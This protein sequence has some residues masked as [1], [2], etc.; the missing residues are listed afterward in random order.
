[1]P[2]TSLRAP[3]NFAGHAILGRFRANNKRRMR[4]TLGMLRRV[5]EGNAMV[6]CEW[7]IA[8]LLRGSTDGGMRR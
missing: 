6:I 8:I 7:E 1:M 5:D 4:A 3:A 2:R